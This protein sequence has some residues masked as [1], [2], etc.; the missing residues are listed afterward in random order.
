MFDINWI[1]DNLEEFKN[2]LLQRGEDVDIKKLLSLDDARRKFIMEMQSLQQERNEKSKAIGAIKDKTG[3]EFK[4]AKDNVQKVNQQIESLKEDERK[5]EEDFTDFLSRI[6][7]I[8]AADIPEGKDENDNVVITTNGTPR[9]FD[10]EPKPHYEIGEKLGMMDFEQAVKISGSRF[11][12]LKGQLSR[13]E[14]ALSNL[15]LDV[16]T[17]EFGFEEVSPSFL[18]KDNAMYGTGQLPK[19]AEDSFQTKEGLW[20]IPTAEVSITNMVS[21]KIIDQEDLPLRYVAYTPCFRS[22]AGSAGKDTRG[23]IRLHQFSK[24]EL[25]TIANQEKAEEEYENLLKSAEAILIKLG[26]PYRKVLL[27][28][29]DTGFSAQKTY[30]LEVWLPSQKTYREIS[31]C[32]IFGDFQAR[33]MK[34]RYR[35]R[36]EKETKFLHT[37]NGSGLAIGR[38]IVAIIENY[39]NKDGSIT[40]PPALQKYMGGE[41]VISSQAL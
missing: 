35:K 22:E 2:A 15:M 13:L 17:N 11:V 26:L 34:A 25:V 21:D 32:S 18:V 14:R 36:G 6:P 12:N 20:L 8:L 33:R 1:K 37:M 19:F 39:Q 38:T 3:K 7:N 29:G 24:V 5:A 23:M 9:E 28:S 4:E 27:C 16:H 41:S 30:D 10:F 31:S 40:I